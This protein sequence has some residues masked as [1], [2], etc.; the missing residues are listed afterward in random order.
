MRIAF[1]AVVLA[2]FAY[3]VFD[4]AREYIRASGSTWDR[5]IAAGKGSATIVWQRF[6]MLISAVAGGLASLADWLNA[7]GLA[8][9]IKD[10]M[11]PEY[12]AFFMIAVAIITEIAR[13]RT[14]KSP[15]N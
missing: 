11:T 5:L 3:V 15:G 14:L 1:T 8:D 2:I 9:A 4:F 7:P 6:V 13:R 12:V 10:A